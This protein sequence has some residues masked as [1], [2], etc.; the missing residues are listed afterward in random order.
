MTSGVFVPMGMVLFEQH[1]CLGIYNWPY[2]YWV[3]DATC[4][5]RK[6]ARTLAFLLCTTGN[7][8]SSYDHGAAVFC[9]RKCHAGRTRRERLPRAGS[10]EVPGF[11][12]FRR[13]LHARGKYAVASFN[14]RPHTE[15]VQY[16]FDSGEIASFQA[17]VGFLKVF[18]YRD[19]E[20]PLGWNIR[21]C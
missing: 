20:L 17:M 3:L 21:A 7:R 16:G 5:Q 18:G 2:V 13:L 10:P 14:R 1:C 15:V 6:G 4:A 8:L 19:P 11:F 9:Y 12:F